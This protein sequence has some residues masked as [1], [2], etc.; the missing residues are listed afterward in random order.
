MK[1]FDQYLE[2]FNFKRFVRSYLLIAVIIM[3]VSFCDVFYMVRSKINMALRYKTAIHEFEHRDVTDKLKKDLNKLSAAS[4]DI[5]NVLIVGRDNQI[6]YK[7][8]NKL[9]A[10]SKTFNLSPYGWYRSYLQDTQHP[11]I[12]YKIDRDKDIILN[13]NY[14]NDHHQMEQDIDESFSYQQD[15]GT[16]TV[17]LLNYS[18]N[19]STGDRLYMIRTV[20]SIPRLDDMLEIIAMLAL[21]IFGTYWIALALWVYRDA[22]RKRMS[23]AL[24]GLLVLL[25]NFPGL[26]IYILY[27]Q[28]NQLCSKCKAIQ[29]KNAKYCTHCGN[30]LSRTCE[31]CGAISEPEDRYC[32]DCGSQLKSE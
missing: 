18:I 30:K 6:R 16:N 29:G 31:K 32:S 28:N 15:I 7:Q 5:Q 3:L 2:K 11:N 4:R 21:L 20:S 9:L 24:W 25:I 17:Y 19:R 12:L 26:I 10:G 8:N 1:R 23:P 22:S 13:R 27:K 14:I